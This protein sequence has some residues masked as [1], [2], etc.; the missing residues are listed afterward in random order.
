MK[1][2]VI[3]R[4]ELRE[5]PHE[6]MGAIYVARLRLDGFASLHAGDKPGVVVTRSIKV[7]GRHLFVNAN[8]SDGELRAQIIDAK[9]GRPLRSH[10]L[11][12]NVPWKENET[13]ASLQ[14]RESDD[15]SAV[16]DRDVRIEFHLRN[17]H[18]YSFWFSD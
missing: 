17:A 15:V 14:W 6:P 1:Q 3:E 5:S 16:I 4:A 13:C 8:A 10:S 12:N 18:L 9:T 7:T 11:D 2:E